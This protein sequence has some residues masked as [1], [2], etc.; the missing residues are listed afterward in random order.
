[1]KEEVYSEESSAILNVYPNPANSTVMVSFEEWGGEIDWELRNSMGM[2]VRNG[3]FLT[4][5]TRVLNVDLNGV[6]NGVYS[7]SVVEGGQ[8]AMQWIVKK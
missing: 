7:F 6:A 1:M 3:Q 2:L 5:S 4:N 8:R